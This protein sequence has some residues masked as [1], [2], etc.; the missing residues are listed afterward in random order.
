[1]RDLVVRLLEADRTHNETRELLQRAISEPLAGIDDRWVWIRDLTDTWVVWEVEGTGDGIGLFQAD[2]SIDDDGTV[3]LGAAVEVEGRTDYLPIGDA[4]PG[5]EAYTIDRVAGRVL[6]AKGSDAAGGRVFAMQLIDY[7]VSRNGRS[8][9]PEV[10]RGAAR[11]YEGAKAF[12]HHRSLDEMQS[13]TIEGLVGTWRNVN[14]NDTG[15]EGDLHL[16]PSATHTAEALDA[17]LVQQA[18]GLPPL[19]GASHDIFALY[20]PVTVDG[21]RLMEATSI[22]KVNSVDVVADPAA[23]G[24]AT[25]M[26]AGGPGAID[27]VEGTMTLKE[28]LELLRGATPEKR[29]ELLAEHASV[30]ADNG[31]TADQA[32]TLVT[33]P[34]AGD[35][36]PA[37]PP[38][39]ELVGAGV[40]A[41]TEAVY[42]RSSI[43]GR[44][45]VN[46]AVAEAKLP[47]RAAE[48]IAKF[49]P[50][51]YTEAQVTQAIETFKVAAEGVELAGMAPR[52]GTVE[53]GEE[54]RDKVVKRIDATLR[55]NWQEGYSSY[56]EMYEDFTGTRLPR[57][58]ADAAHLIV[59]ESW[60]A[61]RIAGGR[62]TEAVDSTTFGEAL[63]DAITR[64]LI[65]LYRQP[66]WQTWRKIARTS[67]TRD[68]RSQRRDR[69]GGIGDLPTVLEKGA[70][71]DLGDQT[72][73]EATYTVTKKG[74]TESVTFEAVTNDDIGALVRVPEEMARAARRTLHRFVWLDLF[75]SN[76]T[77]TYDSVALF[78][79][80]HGNTTAVALAHAGMNSLRQ[81]MR[82]QAPFGVASRPL[83]I[84]PKILVV[85]NEL[86][87]LA[88]ELTQGDRAVPA[89]TPGASDVP[90]LHRGIDYIVVDDFTDA[91]DW[92]LVADPMDVGLI[93]V[94][95]LGGR[96][97]PEL[98]MQD[99]PK[100]GSVFSADEVTW[101]IRHIYGGTVLDHRAAQRGTQ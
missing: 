39:G 28:L 23:G 40:G 52:A 66:N 84:T 70:Y 72:D 25:R 58:P 56:S 18:Q 3:T 5:T 30:L 1:M 89:T 81:K 79:A 50:E 2:Y 96:E 98:F 46:A 6:E 31:I 24:R 11:L 51:R 99:D 78:D 21:R 29:T 12:D 22:T 85:P 75:A 57:H 69:I 7:G 62:A 19:I 65:E 73:E 93:E 100:V 59:R 94:G 34:P 97:D 86:E 88:Y 35:P 64:R 67:P 71:Q 9:P 61:S 48:S 90:N 13:S 53:V 54:S 91:N 20:R 42:A 68:F 27:P 87:E 33:E 55:R 43:L 77:C 82:D 101:K 74:G 92:Y 47:A 44:Q 26:V 80:A 32:L 60:A 83:G 4:Q 41:A 63:G 36:P 38:A 45:L 49:L 10:L 15:L 95:F 8:Y 17:S 14:A 16:L 76:P 37:D